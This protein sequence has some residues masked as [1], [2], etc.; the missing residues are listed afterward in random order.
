MLRLLTRSLFQ[1]N[2][3]RKENSLH[4]DGTKRDSIVDYPGPAPIS[5]FTGCV[6]VNLSND[7]G[8]TYSQHD[9]SL[10]STAAALSMWFIFGKWLNNLFHLCQV[11]L[12]NIY[13]AHS[14][15][16]T[17]HHSDAYKVNI[18]VEHLIEA[19]TSTIKMIMMFE[20]VQ[21]RNFTLDIHVGPC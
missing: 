7:S 3:K 11:H 16:C 18:L 5:P 6:S 19:L 12:L 20:T 13:C 21:L 8:K 14:R 4:R 17:L 9:D 10:W 15:C 1:K 2:G